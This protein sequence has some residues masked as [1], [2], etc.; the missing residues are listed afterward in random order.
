MNTHLA[1]KDEESNLIIQSTILNRKTYLRCNVNT[2]LVQHLKMKTQ[3]RIDDQKN[4]IR[5]QT[6]CM[7]N[8]E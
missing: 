3:I 8:N 7:M 1:T 2:N 4:T 5:E 6:N